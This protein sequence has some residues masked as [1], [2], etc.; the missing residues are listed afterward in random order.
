MQRHVWLIIGI[1]A[2][3]TPP[4][5]PV[6]RGAPFAPVFCWSGRCPYTH[7][8]LGLDASPGSE[9]AMFVYEDDQNLTATDIVIT[10]GAGGLHAENPRFD[11]CS[12][13]LAPT[14]P[15]WPTIDLTKGAHTT[16]ADVVMIEAPICFAA[17]V[18]DVY[19]P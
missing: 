7:Y 9:V 4:S 14:P 11:A 5:K 1:A 18:V 17:D 15:M 16:L 3:T 13:L 10:A 8:D 2:C 19:Q 6:V 12:S